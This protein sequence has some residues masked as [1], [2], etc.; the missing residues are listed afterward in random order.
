MRRSITPSESM[1]SRVFCREFHR[2]LLGEIYEDPRYKEVETK[3]ALSPFDI[4]KISKNAWYSWW[5]GESFPIEK[6]REKLEKI[7]AIP[8]SKW[9]FPSLTS[10]RL[11]CHLNC[12]E[13]AE[14]AS[15]DSLREAKK[16]AKLILESLHNDWNINSTGTVTTSRSHEIRDKS[17]SNE[18]IW[19]LD[20]EKKGALNHR[21]GRQAMLAY[22]PIEPSS[23]INFLVNLITEAWDTEI[24]LNEVLTLDLASALHAYVFLVKASGCEPAASGRLASFAVNIFNFLHSNECSSEHLGEL[25]VT[26][27]TLI[28]DP[29]L[30]P[31]AALRKTY[32]SLMSLRTGLS[33]TELSMLA[34]GSLL[35]T[36]PKKLTQN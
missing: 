32:Q 7:T 23:I 36:P 24:G 28:E 4:S 6:S 5:N 15:R 12:F 14:I 11:A 3:L 35:L 9:L 33:V 27:G 26:L 13:L 34:T 30:K 20:K 18:V 25:I 2:V 8:A 22:E 17:R 16:K 21:A 10:N 29:S 1:R 31:I 19:S